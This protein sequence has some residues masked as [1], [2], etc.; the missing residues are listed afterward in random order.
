MNDVLQ[1]LINEAEAWLKSPESG[2]DDP[3][4]LLTALQEELGKDK[5]AGRPLGPL[6]GQI[7]SI[8]NKRKNRLKNIEPINWVA[9][10]QGR[11]AIGHRPS[12]KL[13]TDIQLQGGSHI[14]TLLSETEG[15][16]DIESKVQKEGLIWLWF[17]M[18]SADPPT[19]DRSHELKSLFADMAKALQGKASIYMHCSAGIH[20]TGMITYAFLR[21]L[22]QS[23]EIAKDN[24]RHLRETTWRE[25]GE[26]RL[27]WGERFGSNT[28]AKP[29]ISSK[30]IIYC[31]MDGVL[32]DFTPEAI[33]LCSRILD[34]SSE[35][36]RYNVSKTARKAKRK[37]RN[38]LGP[39][40]RPATSQDLEISPVKDMYFAA[41]GIAPGEFFAGLKP[42]ADAMELLWPYINNSNHEVQLLSA[43]IHTW[44]GYSP[45][46]EATIMTAEDGKKQWA[47]E[48]LNPPP[49]EII[50]TP[51]RFKQECAKTGET[52]NILIDDREENIRDW[53]AFGGIGI[54]H[55]MGNSART[56]EEL[57]R[58][59]I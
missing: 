29:V 38:T 50:I 52:P 28:E 46:E 25:V 12:A 58:L 15:A 45:E 33:D 56:I 24:L 34:D 48:F 20:R 59:G 13:I 32:A 57:K 35:V 10:K 27:L 16:R 44:R 53:N 39:D 4:K 8:Q 3:E 54:L 11:L 18:Q 36:E 17:A 14:L 41:I 9:I 30:T 31:D 55:V 40:W 2:T 1:K 21:Y 51:A 5:A 37:I 47:G 26:K 42:L 6:I 23:P 22:G 43:P 19:E 7:K 49:S